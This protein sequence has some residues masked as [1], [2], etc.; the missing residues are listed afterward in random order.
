[1]STDPLMWK[2]VWVT[3]LAEG[4]E[5]HKKYDQIIFLNLILLLKTLKKSWPIH[6]LFTVYM[7]EMHVLF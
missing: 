7:Y 6:M 5:T 2:S 3:T 4:A 1:M